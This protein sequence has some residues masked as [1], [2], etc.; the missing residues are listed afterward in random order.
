MVLQKGSFKGGIGLQG[1]IW[2]D[3]GLGCRLRVFL[4]ALVM[5]PCWIEVGSVLGALFFVYTVQ[6]VCTEV[7]I[8]GPEY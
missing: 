1:R 3:S 7:Q 4:W 5:G 6:L 2:L 8:R